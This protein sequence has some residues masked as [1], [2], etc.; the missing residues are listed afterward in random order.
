[1]SSITKIGNNIVVTPDNSAN[2]ATFAYSTNCLATW[3][4]ESELGDE[5]E[6]VNISLGNEH[7]YHFGTAWANPV[8]ELTEI[9]GIDVSSFTA[10][11]KVTLIQNSVF[12]ADQFS[13]TPV[14]IDDT[15][16]YNG[17][18][19]AI[20]VIADAVLDVTAD[21]TIQVDGSGT[22]IDMTP[23]SGVTI[24]AWSMPIYGIFTQI[25]LVSGRVIAYSNL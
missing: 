23:Y 16:E 21:A 7:G 2:S 15:S 20:Q 9:N 5:S 6:F 14:L 25:Q 17:R 13:G 3:G 4:V 24:P 12:T 8:G 11:E 10:E 19:T 1:M 22:V 18:F